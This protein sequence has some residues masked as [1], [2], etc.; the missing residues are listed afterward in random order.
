MQTILNGTILAIL[1]IWIIRLYMTQS[2][3]MRT[4][5]FPYKEGTKY[6]LSPN[7][8]FCIFTVCTSIAYL[9][10]FSLLK[11]GIWFIVIILLL[12]SGRIRLNLHVVVIGYLLFLAW[13]FVAS[14]YS[15][16][17]IGYRL[18]SY[19][20]YSL[21]IFYLWLGY[22]AIES[23]FSLLIFSRVVL[24][25]IFTYTFFIGG[26][27]A[28]V[29]PFIYYSP[30]GNGV[31]LTYAGFADY[32]TSLFPLPFIMFYLTKRKRYLLIASA[33]VLSSILDVVRTGLGGLFIS[34]VIT[35]IC[36]Y[37]ARSIPYL[38]SIVLV[39]T[40]IVSLI[41]SV[42]EK[43]FYE[44]DKITFED[45]ST[46]RNITSEDI[47]DNGRYELWEKVMNV[48]YKEKELIGSG[49]GRTSEWLWNYHLRIN[50]PALLHND[51]VLILCDM[52]LVGLILF[53][54]FALLFIYN[55]IYALLN[56]YHLL[57]VRVSAILALVSF[58]GILFA[59]GFDNVFGHSMTSLI[60]PFIFM[61]FFL[62][63]K[64][65]YTKGHEQSNTII[66]ES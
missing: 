15:D 13:A 51:Y 64:E 7:L 61:G 60:N 4:I 30:V 19:I 43:M 39:T 5:D 31:F 26:F 8:Y 24:F 52:G 9:S 55:C 20:R 32:L 6:V 62:K 11:Y 58:S 16:A 41:P 50:S 23:K 46:G 35:I 34:S 47:R 37:R 22:N 2:V 56:S 27:G 14:I 44:S 53:I 21:P 66:S 18:S 63:F 59:M 33:M 29:L 1:T 28:I 25:T 48:L 49:T 17:G 45:V 10:P 40:S 3:K 65:I 36:L 38:L 54:L 12:L 42:R 57:W